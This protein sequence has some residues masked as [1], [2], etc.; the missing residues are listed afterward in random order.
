M[1]YKEDLLNICGCF[2]FLGAGMVLG[3]HLIDSVVFLG[4]TAVF[5]HAYIQ[6]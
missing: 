2:A 4:L 6:I 3:N 1:M 5:C